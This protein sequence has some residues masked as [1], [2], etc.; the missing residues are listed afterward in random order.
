MHR[1]LERQIRR[2]L[3]SDEPDAIPPAW[4]ALLQAVSDT[5]VHADDDRALLSRSLDLSSHEFSEMNTALRSENEIVERKVK[6][7]MQDLEHERAKLAEIAEQMP[8]GAILLDK[9]G[10]VSFMNAAVMRFF[11]LI[12]AQLTVAVMVQLFPALPI[13]DCI[14]GALAGESSDIP[15]AEVLARIFAISFV[16]LTSASEVFGVMI[17]IDDI[18]AQKRLERSKNQFM[19]IASHEMRTPLAIIRSNAELLLDEEPI[20]GDPG[21]K[22]ET[23]RILKGSVRLLGIV[24]DFLDVQNVEEKKIVLAPV[25]VDIASLIEETIADLRGLAGAKRITLQF[26]KPDVPLPPLTLDRSR[27]QQI[28]IN[29]ISNAVHYTDQGGVT[30]TLVR[31]DGSVRILVEDTGVGMDAEDQARLF[32]KFQTGKAFLK[33]REYGSGLGLYISRLLADLMGMKIALE[34]SAVG[35]GSAFSLTIPAP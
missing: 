12:E 25:S 22:E 33:S 13:E 9:D 26:T 16:S 28:L 10:R 20:I 11:G 30:V 27:M 2:Y 19:A 15:E 23:E 6:D 14:Q 7:R 21:A 18:T 8:T 29:L 3:G 5:Y 4:K 32:A 17:W 24:N 31:S 34:R 35:Q 1:V